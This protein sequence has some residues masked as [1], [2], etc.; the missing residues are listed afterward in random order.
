MIIP[1][2]GGCRVV[3]RGVILSVVIFCLALL[4]D[5]VCSQ[6]LNCNIQVNAMKLEGTHRV[7]F[8]TLERALYEFMN[9]QAWTNHSFKEN[10]RIEC[11]FILT[12][13]EQVGS[14]EYKGTLNVQLRRPVFN[15]S[16][17]TPLFNFMDN[18]IHFKYIENAPLEYTQGSHLNNLTSIFAYYAYMILGYDY[19]TFSPLGGQE[20]YERALAIVE[21]AQN[22]TERGWRAYEGNKKNRYWLVE[23]M[24]NDR[25][26]AFRR[27]LYT[28]HRQGLDAMSDRVSEGRAEALRALQDVQSVWRQKPDPDMAVIQLFI[29]AKR[30][31]VISMFSESPS[32][33]KARCVNLMSEM[34]RGNTSRYGE[35]LKAKPNSTG[36]EG[37]R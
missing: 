37:G 20:F 18:S 2:R 23:N 6:E 29:E 24:L 9:N 36:F 31:E 15:T 3:C 5:G 12:L 32:G 26:R 8:Q 17:N 35:M 25:Y 22:A 28:Y 27:A 30:E 1:R 10:E 34:D 13:N 33:E 7:V 4:P 11:T 16:Y 19:D 21:A 14:D